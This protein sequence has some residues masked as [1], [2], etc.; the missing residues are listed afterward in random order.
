MSKEKKSAW[1]WCSRYIRLR[2]SIEYCREV[3]IPLDS[4]VVRCCTCPAVK[5]W[6]YGDA[7]HFIG[8]GLGGSSGVYF[9]ERNIHFQCKQCNAFLQGNP[10]A[11]RKFMLEKYGEEIVKELYAK[12]HTNSYKGQIWAIGQMY[13]Q[14]Y[15]ELKEKL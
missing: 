1:R 15:H 2:D 14:M 8:R 13:K 6:K 4:G 9:A 3:N 12:H 11:Y 7:G 10:E 5:Q